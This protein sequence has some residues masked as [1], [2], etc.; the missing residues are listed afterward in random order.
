MST[1]IRLIPVFMPESY[2]VMV[3]DIFLMFFIIL[4]IFYIP[5]EISF[6]LNKFSPIFDDLPAFVLLDDNLD[7][8]W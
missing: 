1:N 6:N 8:S 2:G 7:V 3:W 5:L 4:N